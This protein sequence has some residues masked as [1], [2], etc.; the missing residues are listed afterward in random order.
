LHH[1]PN[2]PGG[3][4]ENAVPA[5]PRN[6]A[7]LPKK[8]AKLSGTGYALPHDRLQAK[9]CDRG[10]IPDART[11]ALLAR[12]DELA[13]SIEPSEIGALPISVLAAIDLADALDSDADLEDG[14]DDELRDED[15]TDCMYPVVEPSVWGA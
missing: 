14:V 13:L 6:G 3:A 9:L 5:G 10:L 4:H 8:A 2:W 15:G 7:K 1:C 12:L 11:Q